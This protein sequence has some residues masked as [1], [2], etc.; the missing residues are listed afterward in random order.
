MG[1]QPIDGRCACVRLR[2]GVDVAARA[3]DQSHLQEVASAARHD[4]PLLSLE[5]VDHDHQVH[6]G[7][8][9]LDGAVAPGAL[10]LVVRILSGQNT[11]EAS[12]RQPSFSSCLL[13]SSLRLTEM[14]I[15]GTDSLNF[16]CDPRILL[17]GQVV[18]MFGWNKTQFQS[19]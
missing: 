13:F 5:A 2:R 18:P 6:V 1:E 10:H 17:A 7:V 16:V 19:N 4:G 15:S 8:L 3:G 9:L 11:Q 12:D 14:Y